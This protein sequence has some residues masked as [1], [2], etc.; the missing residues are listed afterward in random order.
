MTAAVGAALALG[1]AYA[2]VGAAVAVVATATRTLHLAVGPV[3]VAGVLTHLV[4]SSPA[5]GVPV[6]VAL[7]VAL[8]VGATTSA[9]LGPL[10]LERLPDGLPALVGLVVAAGLLDA[11]LARGVTARPVAARPLLDLPGIGGVAPAVTTAVVLGVPVVLALTVT[12]RSTRWG[13][14]VRLVG[15]SPAAA[16]AAGVDPARTRTSALAVGGAVAVLAGLLAA[17][18]V[19]VGTA[20]AA[21]L[22]VRGVAAGAL[23]GAG[24]P[25]AA[26]AGGLL[27][28]TVEV[29]GGRLW[30]AAGAEVAVAAVVVAVLAVRGGT[31][32]RAWGRVW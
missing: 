19:T 10:V 7:L 17:P 2:A 32:L 13:R 16:V 1:A 27:L 24:G 3:L 4:L 30:P 18:L 25:S 12:L 9:L 31:H 5:V 14:A 22:T 20:Q 29:V 8:L 6:G 28:G 15:G 26:L 11:A 23:L 21:G